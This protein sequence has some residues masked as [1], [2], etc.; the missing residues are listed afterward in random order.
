[1]WHYSKTSANLSKDSSQGKRNHGYRN[2]LK[3][4]LNQKFRNNLLV[5]SSKGKLT[6]L[7]GS[8]YFI[9]GHVLKIYLLV[10]ILLDISVRFHQFVRSSLSKEV[11]PQNKPDM[12]KCDKCGSPLGD[13]YH[14]YETFS[15]H[16]IC[17]LPQ[18]KNGALI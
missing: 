9:Q 17:E 7:G 12:L 10:A 8:D 15:R 4:L 14:T 11:K 1:M 13:W 6:L 3:R 16:Y 2:L 5:R 18:D